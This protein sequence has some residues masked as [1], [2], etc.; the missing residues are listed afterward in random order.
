MSRTREYWIYQNRNVA[1]PWAISNCIT[2][3]G[4]RDMPYAW[5]IDTTVY[6]DWIPGA[7]SDSSMT[8]RTFRNG[9][10]YAFAVAAILGKYGHALLDADI[11]QL[12]HAYND[13]TGISYR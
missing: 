7:H 1:Q 5:R 11:A 6:A 9:E 10:E 13:Q 2:Y 4:Y 8:N 3:T 12:I